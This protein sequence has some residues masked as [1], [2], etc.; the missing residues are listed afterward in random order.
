MITAIV[1]YTLPP[2]IGRQECLEHFSAI[3]PDSGRSQGF[4]ASISST[5]TQALAGACICGR[6]AKMPNGS[7]LGPGWMA[8]ASAMVSTPR[9]PIS[10]PW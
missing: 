8:F 6:A 7:I 3:A 2:S 4:F 10:K 9:S 5:V 1:E